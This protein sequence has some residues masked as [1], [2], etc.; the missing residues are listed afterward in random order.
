[1]KK[2][3]FLAGVE[4]YNSSDIASL[5][6]AVRD[7][8]KVGAVL[9]QRCGFQPP[10]IL[11]NPTV[12]DLFNGLDDMVKRVRHDDI[13]FFLFTGHG[14]ELKDDAREERGYLLMRDAVA[15]PEVTIGKYA[16]HD[17]KKQ[18]QR[19]DCRQRL[20]F[21]DCCRNYP[22]LENDGL[23]ARG[24]AGNIMG[25][26]FSRDIDFAGT[27]QDAQ[28]QVTILLKAC[29]AGQRAYEWHK[30]KH[31]V[32]SYYLKKGLLESAWKSNALRA[33]E[34]CRYVEREVGLWSKGKAVVQIPD[35]VQLESAQDIILARDEVKPEQDLVPCAICGRYKEVGDTFRCPACNTD[36]ICLDC[37][38]KDTRICTRCVEKAEKR[39]P[40][41]K[42]IRAGMVAVVVLLVVAGGYQGITQFQGYL[43]FP[44]PTKSRQKQSE[45]LPAHKQPPVNE[46]PLPEPVSSKPATLASM[47]FEPGTC[48]EDASIYFAD[49]YKQLSSG[50]L[51]HKKGDMAQF[52]TRYNRVC[53][54]NNIHFKDI[55]A[56]GRSVPQSWYLP[57]EKNGGLFVDASSGDVLATGNEMAKKLVSMLSTQDENICG[58]QPDQLFSLLQTIHLRG[59]IA[60]SPSF[61]ERAALWYNNSCGNKVVWLEG[62]DIDYSGTA[63]DVFYYA[64]PGDNGIFV[65][66]NGNQ[67]STGKKFTQGLSDAID[68]GTICSSNEDSLLTLIYFMD[69]TKKIQISEDF[70]GTLAAHY[71][72]KCKN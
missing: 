36:H 56:A 60:L 43:T 3:A 15:D 68:K 11:E 7:V 16:L 21:F 14:Q 25:S 33:T 47:T 69:Q 45:S 67:V 27:S 62:V 38:G 50:A 24:V 59:G 51:E 18:L 70:Y 8:K 2:Y 52:F 10:E 19:I 58:F 66:I 71:K 17:L 40:W 41:A 46:A 13:F 63:Q 55:R 61:W 57:E 49:L 44:E 20:L 48:P 53:G 9:E 6:Y 65:D 64:D 32:F 28:G 39:K 30:E 4:E 42:K 31:G 72:K 37:R 1:M 34:L 54:P 5:K 26:I 35:F 23:S 29:K 12:S 22:E